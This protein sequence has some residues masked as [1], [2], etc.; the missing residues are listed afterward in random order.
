MPRLLPLLLLL[1]AL[2]AAAQPR[3][4]EP[5][6]TAPPGPLQ[7]TICADAELRAADARL[8]GLERAVAAT[9]A[10]PATMALRAATWQRD[11]GNANPGARDT[12]LDLYAER[13]DELTERLR[14]DRALRRLEQGRESGPTF[15]RPATLET[16]CLG[17][18]LRDCRVT[19]AGMARSADG[20][21]RVLWQAQ[22]GHT[23]R[24]GI[25]AGIVLLAEVRGGWRLLGWSFEGTRFDPPRIVE[26]DGQRL[27]HLPGRGGTTGRA[28]ADLFYLQQGTAW[29]EIEAESWG[30]ALAAQ[31]P[32]GLE[33]WSAAEYD[34]EEMTARL[35]LGRADTDPGCCP[36]AGAAFADLVVRRRSLAL[37][38][39]RLDATARAARPAPD[40]ACSAE[41]ATYRMHAPSGF[42]ADLV[43]GWP[44]T[45]AASD[46]L[47]RVTSA[48]TGRDYWFGFAAAQGYGGLTLL[49]VE[50]PGPQTREDGVQTLDIGDDLLPLL[51]VWPLTGELAVLETPPH[52][53]RP[54]PRWLFTPG[55]GQALH[56][57][58]LPGQTAQEAMPPAL[59]ALSGC[60]A[61]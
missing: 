6:C 51:R 2:P 50:A 28:S 18:V 40:A 37:A 59:W 54:A 45:G 9:T 7:A 1:L 14:Q 41:R 22:A 29:A 32:A 12:L 15:P 55:L 33:P 38:E 20:R 43:G 31:L 46:L 5:A 11:M 60:R 26:Q 36:S 48:A 27:L 34:A 17:A 49:P 53:G 35:V 30:E 42:T 13:S 52:S 24:D 4:A 8:R 21:A 44:G 23:E 19:G 16:A 3:R 47:L 58:Q 57:Q 10:R 56:Y 61:G 25:R 39:L